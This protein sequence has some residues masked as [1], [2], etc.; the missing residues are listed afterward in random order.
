MLVL[1]TMGISSPE[2]VP[3][4]EENRMQ[5]INLYT[6]INRRMQLFSLKQ[7]KKYHQA[8]DR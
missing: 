3:A 6:E 8:N 2:M 4:V 5:Q 7:T 1:D